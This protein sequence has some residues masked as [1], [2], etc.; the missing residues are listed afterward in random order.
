[1]N[2]LVFSTLYPNCIQYRHGIFVAARMRKFAELTAHKVTVVAPVPWFP[3]SNPRFGRYSEFNQ[4]PAEEEVNGIKVYHPRYPVLP[5]VGMSI[6]PKLMYWC[7]R[8]FMANLLKE[9]PFDLIDAHYF[10]PDG[11]AAVELGRYLNRPVVVSARGQDISLIPNYTL[12]RYQIVRAANQASQLVS[13]AK[14][15]KR[16]MEEM[17]ITTPIHLLQNGVDLA[18][19]KPAA[20]R[21]RL[22]QALGLN[23]LTLLSVGNTIELKGHH[24]VI[25]ALTKLPEAQLVVIGEGSERIKYQQLAEQLGVADRVAFTGNIQQG[26]LVQYYNAA[27]VLVLA[28]RR[29]GCPNVVLEA[30]ACGTPVIATAVGAVPDLIEPHVSG[31]LLPERSVKSIV[32]M[33]KQWQQSPLGREQVRKHTEQFGWE[34]II[35]SL[36]QVFL[37]VL[38][39]YSHESIIDIQ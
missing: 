10:Y 14:P 12:P 5:K 15:L 24:L 38:T 6:A 23:G 21:E 17:G 34:T 36:E 31:Y 29:E 8:K 33:V 2:I 20:D 1:M 18:L 3:S 16:R 4:V 11:V 28:S 35:Q 39:T 22:R 13:V 27:D 25:E 19:F 37:N 7:L 30:M 32:T 9:Q 26:D